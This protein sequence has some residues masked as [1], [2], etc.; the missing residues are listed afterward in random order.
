[1]NC[2]VREEVPGISALADDRRARMVRT[3]SR[4][5]AR[6]ARTGTFDPLVVGAVIMGEVPGRQVHRTGDG[7]RRLLLQRRDVRDVRE[8]EKPPEALASF[9]GKALEGKNEIELHWEPVRRS[10]AGRSTGGNPEAV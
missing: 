1:V 3:G 4:Y 7:R 5:V 6:R 2:R 10:A 8:A 9:I